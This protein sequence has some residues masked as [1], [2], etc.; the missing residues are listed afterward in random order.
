[1]NKGPVLAVALLGLVSG[2][3]CTVRTTGSGPSPA[4]PTLRV[5][6]PSSLSTFGGVP[7]VTGGNLVTLTGQARSVESTAAVAGLSSVHLTGAS[8]LTVAGDIV[9]AS[10]RDHGSGTLTAQGSDLVLAGSG[11]QLGGT[12]RVQPSAVTVNTTSLV[13]PAS[14]TITSAHLSFQPPT[15]SPTPPATAAP[16]PPPPVPLAGPVTIRGTSPASASVAGPNLRWTDAP[17]DIGVASGEADFS[18]AGSGS[19]T[20]AGGSVKGGYLGVRAQQLSASLHRAASNVAVQGTGL[21]LQVYADGVPQV[22]V[23]ARFDVLS[24]HATTGSFFSLRPA[25]VWT[26][27]NLDSTYDMAILRIRPGN[28]AAGGVHIGLLPMPPMFGG[29]PHALVGGA[30][31]GLK[32]GD[33]IDSLVARNGDDKRS[34]GYDAPVGSTLVLVIEGN[35]DPITVTVATS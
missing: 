29:E 7:T 11:V 34:I 5:P 25:F 4:G 30:T 8:V 17:A 31:G 2:A 23:A 26:P 10:G 27:R 18:W 6:L 15:P 16:S 35:F 19:I 13:L 32:S 1:M 20:T 12:L 28:A 3:C 22:R 24:T 21:A 14:S 33:P 9:D